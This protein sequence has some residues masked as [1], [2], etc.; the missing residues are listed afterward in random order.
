MQRMLEELRKL[1]VKYRETN[2]S[3]KRVLCP[4][5][6]QIFVSKS[7]LLHHIC[8]D[9]VRYR[10]A[11]LMALEDRCLVHHFGQLKV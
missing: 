5:C 9:H 10:D 4:H 7:S 11:A 3:D 6:L 8:R 2:F 1:P